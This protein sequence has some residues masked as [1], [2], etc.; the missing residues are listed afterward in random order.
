MRL[1]IS[2]VLY[3][4]KNLFFTNEKGKSLFSSPKY[5]A[6]GRNFTREW[7]HDGKEYE[8]KARVPAFLKLPDYLKETYTFDVVNDPSDKT[9]TFSSLD[10][11]DL[12]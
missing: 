7:R 2:K 8:N 3:F 5:H 12:Q 4:I 1:S 11:I 6:L 10:E 9:F